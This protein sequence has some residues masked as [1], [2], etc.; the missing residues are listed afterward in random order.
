MYCLQFFIFAL[1]LTGMPATIACRF[2][3]LNRSVISCEYIGLTGV[4]LDGAEMLACGL[5]THF[6]H[7]MRLPLLEE[8]LAKVKTSNPNVVHSVI[9]EFSDKAPVKESSALQSKRFR[10]ENKDLGILLDCC[11]DS[12]SSHCLDCPWHPFQ[13]EAVCRKTSI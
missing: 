7:S 5:A 8:A 9:D 4:R 11:L 12:C 2:D 3:V 1:Y 6:V 10:T 13:E